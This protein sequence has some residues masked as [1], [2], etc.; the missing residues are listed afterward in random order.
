MERVHGAQRIR[1]MQFRQNIFQK[2]PKIAATWKAAGQ[3]RPRQFQ[4]VFRCRTEFEAALGYETE[5]AKEKAWIGQIPRLLKKNQP[6]HDGKILVGKTCSPSFQLPV[7]ERLSRRHFLE[8]LS[9]N[10]GD[11]ACVAKVDTHPIGDIRDL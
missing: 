1:R 4:L 6:I 9:G 5:G 10:T 8:Q 7:K 11:G 3:L 2:P